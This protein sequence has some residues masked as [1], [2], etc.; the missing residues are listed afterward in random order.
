MSEDS[1]RNGVGFEVRLDLLAGS[2]G[3]S[4]LFASEQFELVA[5]VRRARLTRVAVAQEHTRADGIGKFDSG[6][7]GVA[8]LGHGDVVLC[9][10]EIQRAE[11]AEGIA[12]ATVGG[13]ILP[14]ITDP[15]HVSPGNRQVAVRFQDRSGS[16][17]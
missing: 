1:V 17:V 10:L 9:R 4:E 5:P 13:Q 11:D 2:P 15:I 7:E 8:T 12:R 16:P 3:S 14:R 6:V